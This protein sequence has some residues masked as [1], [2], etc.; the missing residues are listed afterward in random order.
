MADLA[1]ELLDLK[2]KID[3]ANTEAARLEGQIS[4]LEKQRAE[5]FGCA[6]DAD[7]DA[8]IEELS[9]DIARL[10]AELDEGLRTIKDELGWE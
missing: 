3:E 2:K 6:T 4:Q 9:A 1:K 5:E 7:A 8:Y 10:E